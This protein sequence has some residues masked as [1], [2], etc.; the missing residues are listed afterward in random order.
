MT[1]N[2]GPDPTETTTTDLTPHGPPSPDPE[3]D[4]L[5]RLHPH[6]QAVVHARAML[7]AEPQ[8][9]YAI[10][11]MFLPGARRGWWNSGQPVHTVIGVV[12]ISREKSNPTDLVPDHSWARD[13]AAAI[14]AARLR[15]YAT[16]HPDIRAENG[17]IGVV[18]WAIVRAGDPHAAVFED[19]LRPEE[20]TLR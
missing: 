14:A 3:Q 1:Q 20:L 19:V 10:I 8:A 6:P 11:P 13:T 7:A 18:A 17:D 2:P 16:E 15:T 4:R 12:V 5:R 9:D